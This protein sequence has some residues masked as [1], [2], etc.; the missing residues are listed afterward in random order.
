ML[1]SV[2]EKSLARLLMWGSA[3]VSIFVVWSA[4]T[5]PVNV[6]KLLALGGVS[7]AAIAIALSF[8][9]TLIWNE[10]KVVVALLLLFFLTVINSAVQSN[11]PLTQVL[12]GAYGR[13]TGLISYLLLILLFAF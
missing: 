11:A 4:V 12:Y 1:N 9:S 6:T 2:A 5:D 10:H 8:G 3:F 13:N 7:G